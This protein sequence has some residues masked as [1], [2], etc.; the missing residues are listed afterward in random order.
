[1]SLTDLQ[2]FDHLS[3]VLCVVVDG[4]QGHALTALIEDLQRGGAP[5]RP[6]N[7]ITC[8]TVENHRFGLLIQE[9]DEVIGDGQQALALHAGYLVFR[10][11]LPGHRPQTSQLRPTVRTS[12]IASLVG[13]RDEWELPSGLYWSG[14]HMTLCQIPQILLARA[15]CHG[16]KLV[17]LVGSVLGVDDF[18]Q[19][20]IPEDGGLGEGHALGYWGAEDG[21]VLRTG[22][23]DAEIEKWK[24]VN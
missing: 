2:S 10:V 22:H 7:H 23:S 20:E 1:M 18:G 14:G 17:G 12:L 11:H 8:G 15:R 6:A 13:Q 9:D 16:S 4:A 21:N 3:K 5:C 24:F 19:Q